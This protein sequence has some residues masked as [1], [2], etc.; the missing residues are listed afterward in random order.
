MSDYNGELYAE[1]CQDDV[2]KYDNDDVE[3]EL[4]KDLENKLF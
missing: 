3:E 2:I 4:L 1:M